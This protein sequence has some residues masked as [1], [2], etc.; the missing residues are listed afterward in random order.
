VPGLDLRLALAEPAADGARHHKGGDQ[1]RGVE[2]AV[3]LAPGAL[4]VGRLAANLR[5]Q[6]LQ[7]GDGLLEDVP[8]DVDVEV[9]LEVVA[10]QGLD[11]VEARIGHLEAFQV[12]V[13]REQPAVVGVDLHRRVAAVDGLKET[14]ELLPARD[15]DE[16]LGLGGEGLR[17][18]LRRQEPGV[19]AKAD[20]Q[21]AVEDLLR[22]LQQPVQVGVRRRAGGRRVI[23]PQ[24]VEQV[25]AQ[26]A[27]EDV[28][29]LADALLLDVRARRQPLDGALDLGG[30]PEEPLPGQQKQEAVQHLGVG[31]V[32]EREALA[33]ALA[34]EGLL[35]L[36][37]QRAVAGAGRPV[38]GDAPLLVIEGRGEAAAGVVQ[39]ATVEEGFNLE[40]AVDRFGVHATS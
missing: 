13:G 3:A 22:Q 25:N 27:V 35:L 24:L 30:G 9:G 2:D 39:E 40:G 20:E 11:A 14:A 28:E 7:V 19:L 16:A 23:G 37:Q 15:L 31:Q 32:G 34:L 12:R 8:K 5:A 38:R 36:A 17:Q 21:A 26:V 6:G 29:R 33:I 10:G 4:G 18:D 1:L